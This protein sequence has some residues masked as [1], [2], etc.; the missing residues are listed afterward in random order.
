SE[1]AHASACHNTGPERYVTMMTRAAIL[2]GGRVFGI[3]GNP[4]QRL[5]A[6]RHERV[7]DGPLYAKI[8]IVKAY[9][10]FAVLVIK[11]RNLI[12]HIGRLI[13]EHAESVRESRR[14]PEQ[15]SVFI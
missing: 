7:F 5:V 10:A 6:V 11:P 8:G 13:A 2:P 14:Y 4:H 15:F 12:E 1:S 3:F 9:A